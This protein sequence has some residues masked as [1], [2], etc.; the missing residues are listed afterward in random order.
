MA[1]TD[2]EI[3]QIREELQTC[4][5]PLIFFHDDADGLCSFLLLYR[6][7]KE[8]KGIIVKTTPDVDEKFIKKVEEYQ[9]DKIFIVDLAIVQQEFI[10]KIK[11]KIIWIDHHKPLK[12]ENVLYFN[13]RKHDKE[14]NTPVSSLCYQVVQQDMWIAAAGAIADWHWPYFIEEF[15]KE[16]PD[17]LPESI[18]N[19]EDALFETKL[20][21]L[22]DIISFSLKGTTQDA[23]KYA[24]I[25]TRIKTPYEI[26]DQETPKGKYIYKN[27]E[28]IDKEY[29][30]ML[31]KALKVKPRGKILLFEYQS[32]KMSFTKDIANELLHRNPDKLTIIAREKDG[33]MKMSIRSK[34][35][36]IPP[37]LEK[38]LKETEGYGGG[39]EHACGA[40][41]K[42]QDFERFLDIFKK[43]L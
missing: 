20:G 31:K 16:Y 21:K 8:G 28:K 12:R 27:F 30:N 10:D 39:H 36:I 6:Y 33:E 4:K 18:D 14:D 35:I 11:P 17:L 43:N 15:R 40:N 41:V 1:L 22:I 24:K 2:K 26:L 25:F 29:Q 19:P 23:L 13:P 9:P 5:K 7:I 38:A 32:G 3:N 42:K 37:I 34:N